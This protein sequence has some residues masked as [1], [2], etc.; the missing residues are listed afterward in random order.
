MQM[1]AQ[2]CVTLAIIYESLSLGTARVLP[3]YCSASAKRSVSSC[4]P[5]HHHFSLPH[6]SPTF[7]NQTT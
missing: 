3:L 6:A 2:F 4:F 5:T 7:Y 1:L